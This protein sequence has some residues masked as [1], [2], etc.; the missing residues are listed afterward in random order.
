[1]NALTD[2]D[3]S[4]EEK[5][6]AKTLLQ[7]AVIKEKRLQWKT[8]TAKGLAKTELGR[9]LQQ[10]LN[11]SSVVADHYADVV[12]ERILESLNAKTKSR[13]SLIGAINGPKQLC[14]PRLPSAIPAAHFSKHA[15][16]PG[17]H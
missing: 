12:A 14:N 16:C 8:C 10:C 17:R 3:A 11:A 4:K 2:P 9:E 6:A 15:C 13:I 1:L 5:Q 7:L